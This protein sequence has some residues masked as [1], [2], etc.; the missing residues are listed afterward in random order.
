MTSHLSK[1]KSPPDSQTYEKEGEGS[2]EVFPSKW[3]V[4]CH[5]HSVGLAML[6]LRE[7]FGQDAAKDS[8]TIQEAGPGLLLIEFRTP[9]DGISGSLAS[10]FA[11]QGEHPHA[12]IW[13][14]HRHPVHGTIPVTPPDSLM[15]RLGGVFSENLSKVDRGALEPII[16]VRK[17]QGLTEFTAGQI[18]LSLSQVLGLKGRDKSGFPLR[19]QTSSF[20]HRSDDFDQPQ[21]PLTL[22]V[23][24]IGGLVFWGAGFQGLN[25]SPRCGGAYHY[26]K[27]KLRYSR[28]AAKL[29]EIFEVFALPT[30]PSKGTRALDLGAAPGGWTGVLLDLGYDVV[31]VDPGA[32]DATL[33]KNPRVT[34]LRVKTEEAKLDGQMFSLITC[35]ANWDPVGAQAAIG[36]LC[37]RLVPQGYVVFTLK[38]IHDYKAG[39]KKRAS[40][41]AVAHQVKAATEY[42]KKFYEIKGLCQL[43]HN[44]AEVT[45][46]LQKI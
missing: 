19:L 46:V 31:A 42:F 8:V 24:L 9:P 21:G 32:L 41:N 20:F 16:Q 15:E 43:F 45:F 34:H 29:Y 17:I 27:E 2:Q 33:A 14:R 35:D 38:L 28:A 36:H 18:A 10:S 30:N 12:L 39:S 5:E 6:E 13:S 3:L 23:T 1:N 25:W 22:S 26:P 11:R 7:S 37:D 40:L 44:R 4:T